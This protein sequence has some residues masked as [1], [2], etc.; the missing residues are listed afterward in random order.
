[1]SAI[2]WQGRLNEASSPDDVCLVVKAFFASWDAGAFAELPAS[3]R[4]PEDLQ[5]RDISPYAL[6]L[7]RQLGI[8]E[9]DSAP[10]LHEITTFFTKAAL[11]LAQITTQA[12]VVAK[13]ERSKSSD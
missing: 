12:A 6:K 10:R 4:P 13:E 11:R 7:I 9:R 2:G 1:M 8:G 3:C 5:V